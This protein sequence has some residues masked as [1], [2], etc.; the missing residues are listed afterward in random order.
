MAIPAVSYGTLKVSKNSN[1]KMKKNMKIK[2]VCKKAK[3]RQVAQNPIY[4]SINFINLFH[5]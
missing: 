3:E 5:S 1:L 4:S 2:R